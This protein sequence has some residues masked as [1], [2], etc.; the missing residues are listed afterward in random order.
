M[1]SVH[2]YRI[3]SGV[4]SSILLSSLC[5]GQTGL[6]E[7]IKVAITFWTTLLAYLVSWTSLQLTRCSLP[8]TSVALLSSP[9]IGD[10]PIRGWSTISCLLAG[11]FLS[12]AFPLVHSSH[13]FIDGHAITYLVYFCY[14]F[15][16]QVQMLSRAKHVSNNGVELIDGKFSY[17]MLEFHGIPELLWAKGNPHQGPW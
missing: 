10:P 11:A 9:L 2:P 6:G 16:E 13:H 5:M 8:V 12:P 1:P 17:W 7:I 14:D 4:N 3:K 15:S